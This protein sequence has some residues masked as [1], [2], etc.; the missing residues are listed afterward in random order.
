MLLIPQATVRKQRGIW[1]IVCYQVVLE[2]INGWLLFASCQTIAKRVLKNATRLHIQVLGLLFQ[3][4]NWVQLWSLS[5]CPPHH[6]RMSY[7]ANLSTSKYFV[8]WAW[9]VYVR[10]LRFYTLH[11]SQAINSAQTLSVS[12]HL[13]FFYSFFKNSFILVRYSTK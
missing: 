5:R 3:L 2:I 12:I 10:G 7:I 1:L 8:L 9:S 13:S 6:A 4:H 11:N